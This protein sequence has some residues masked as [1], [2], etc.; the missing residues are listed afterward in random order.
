MPA[1]ALAGHGEDRV[2]DELPGTVVGDVAAA[3]GAHELGADVGRRHEHVAEVGAHAERVHVRVLEQQQ[4]VVGASAS[5][6]PCC[7]ACASR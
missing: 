7:S 4:V 6:S 1:A 5:N 3:V 2:A